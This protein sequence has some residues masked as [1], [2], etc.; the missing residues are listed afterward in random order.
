MLNIIIVLFML[1]TTFILATTEKEIRDLK[2]KSKEPFI[3][4][5]IKKMNDLAII[6]EKAHFEDAG[7]DL[8]SSNNATLKAGTQIKVG[9]GIA[10]SVPE[11]YCGIVTGRSGLSSKTPLRVKTGII[12]AGYTGEIAIML[13]Y[14]G[15]TPENEPY[16]I[17]KGD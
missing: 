3:D 10:I 5:P 12:D 14:Q 16:T 11:G 15:V 13:D 9:T 7:Y 2:E 4:L 8:H 17:K 1:V 6:P